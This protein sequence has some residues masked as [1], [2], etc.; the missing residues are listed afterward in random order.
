MEQEKQMILK[1]IDDLKQEEVR[2]AE[3]KMKNTQLLMKEVEESNRKAIMI[4]KEK[5]LEE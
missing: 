2:Q 1:Q 3:E 4:K 5:E